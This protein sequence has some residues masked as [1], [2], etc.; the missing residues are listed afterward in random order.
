[1][2][3]YSIDDDHISNF[4]TEKVLEEAEFS[5]EIQSFL[6]AEDALN[7]IKQDYEANV[8]DII[9][10]DLNMPMMNGWD[11]LD[12]LAPYKDNLLGKCH[13]YIL[14]S[15][16]D[17]SD[18]ARSKDYDLVSGF[19]HKPLTLEDVQVILAEIEDKA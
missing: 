11:F 10:L 13:V 8:P 19:I 17:T 5:T 1:M 4:L 9:F 3:T 2:K 12:A 14:T 7:F 18:T 15:S 16:L 6:S